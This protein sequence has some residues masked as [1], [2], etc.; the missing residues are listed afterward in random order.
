[1]PEG[2]K[3]PGVYSHTACAYFTNQGVHSRARD[4]HGLKEQP[5]QPKVAYLN[6]KTILLPHEGIYFFGGK[7]N[8]E[9]NGASNRLFRLRIYDYPLTCEELQ[10]L[11]KPPKPRYGHSLHHIAHTPYLILFGGRN[12]NFFKIFDHRNCFNEID[13]LSVENLT[14]MK[15][16]QGM[17]KIPPRFSHCSA[18]CGTRLFI[19]GG[20][21][22]KNY[23]PATM[24]I[25]ELDRKK[26]DDLVRI[27]RGEEVPSR[28]QSILAEGGQS[29]YS[30]AANVAY[31][32]A[33]VSSQAQHRPSL[34]LNADQTKLSQPEE[35]FLAFSSPTQR[36]H[37]FSSLSPG[38]YTFKKQGSYMPLPKE[39]IK[40]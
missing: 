8:K 31:S 4:I 35:Q 22:D 38:R 5:G 40:N 36:F 20:V 30:L 3:P 34:S 9:L 11:G 13:I 26:V 27:E 17:G 37:N 1:M 19:F 39:F 29:T 25:L 12:D 16:D 7:E 18:V 15:V 21:G 10:P 28:R 6:N 32:I 33:K 23:L 2:T 24:H 14:W